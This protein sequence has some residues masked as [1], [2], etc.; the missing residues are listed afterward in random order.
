M[1]CQQRNYCEKLGE[2]PCVKMQINRLPADRIQNDAGCLDNGTLSDNWHGGQVEHSG[3][4]VP[5]C[6]RTPVVYTCSGS[7]YQL[8]QMA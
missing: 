8:S 4:A 6:R 5:L 7:T 2:R 3:R 1:S